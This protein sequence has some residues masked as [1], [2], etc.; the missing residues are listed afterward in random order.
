MNRRSI[1]TSL[2]LLA[3]VALIGL[4]IAELQ[5]RGTEGI[6]GLT[7]ADR[8]A[9]AQV[10]NTPAPSFSIESLD[11]GTVSLDSLSG[12][13]GVIN[14]WATWCG[15]C[16]EEAPAFRR[17]SRQYEDRGVRFLGMN[18]RDDRAAAQEF[19]RSFGLDYPSGFDPSGT[20]ADDFRLYAM[21]TTFVIDPAGIIRYRFVGYLTETDLRE[22]IDTLLEEGP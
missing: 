2:V 22:A 12:H 1:L 16:R 18:E 19:M 14:F 13:I 20:L 4:A 9:A 17:L 21:P 5:S 3:A 10:E 8:Q 15:P 6:T 11:G 7:V